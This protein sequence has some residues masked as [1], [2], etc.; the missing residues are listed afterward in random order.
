MTA[1]CIASYFFVKKFAHHIWSYFLTGVLFMPYF[2]YI[3]MQ[4]YCGAFFDLLSLSCYAIFGGGVVLLLIC[5]KVSWHH[6]KVLRAFFLIFAVTLS[7][8]SIDAFVIEPHWLS[9]REEH[10]TTTKL[11]KPLK[12]AVIADLQTDDIGEYERGVFKRIKD[13]EPDL[14]LFAG[15]YIQRYD[16]Q[17]EHQQKL[18]NQILKESGI[19]PTVGTFAAR[20]DADAVEDWARCFDGLP[21]TCKT[22]STTMKANDD[23][24]MTILSL[25]DSRYPPYSP[26]KTDDFHI[27]LGHAPDFALRNPQAD[28]LV[29]GHTHGG[30]VHIPGFGPPVTLSSVPRKWGG[31]CWTDNGTGS[32]LCISRGVG[33]E[34]AYAPRMR[35]LCRPELVFI[36]VIPASQQEIKTSYTMRP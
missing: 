15:D 33:M 11:T 7:A 36:N 27:V 10:M 18:L 35:F 5:A 30:Q 4:L 32:M 31:G 13:Y 26:P 25:N 23:I 16:Q 34:R 19:N 8:I 22:E 20:G 6:F 1:Y 21:Y 29:A 12:I 2:V 17:R 9:V 3:G 14:V 24:T 28:L